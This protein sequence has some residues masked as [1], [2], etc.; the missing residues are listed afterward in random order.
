MVLIQIKRLK[1]Q[2][3]LHEHGKILPFS[4]ANCACLLIC[5]IFRTF[6]EGFL[7]KR[8]LVFTDHQSSFYCAN[9]AWIE[10]LPAS[11]P[12]PRKS[13]GAPINL[14]TTLN[15][16]KDGDYY[17]RLV[18]LY[19][20]RNLTKEADALNAFLGVMHH[21]RQSR[22]AIRTLYC[23]PF[24]GLDDGIAWSPLDGHEDETNVISDSASWTLLDWDGSLQSIDNLSLVPL[25]D[26]NTK[27]PIFFDN[28]LA[29]ALSWYR[30]DE[31]EQASHK[32]RPMFPSWTWI[33]WQGP[34]KFMHFSGYVTERWS[35]VRNVQLEDLS[36]KFLDLPVILESSDQDSIQHAL[37]T[38]E[39]VSFEALVILA[40]YITQYEATNNVDPAS[41]ST[42]D[43]GS[44]KVADQYV[45]CWID[46][47]PG[48]F[49]QLAK[50]VQTG[51]WTCLLIS[52]V[53]LRV[54]EHEKFV[55]VVKWEEDQ[56]TA[57]RV[58]AFGLR[59]L[60]PD[61]A[62]CGPLEETMEWRCV[63]LV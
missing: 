37:S 28:L 44:I 23:L 6:Q 38:V 54:Y 39:I 8:L 36:G 17:T 27:S 57:E 43:S 50:N 26:R 22:P 51:A 52:A 40:H 18:Q 61:Q 31:G 19:G 48:F 21:V 34:V 41:S 46:P 30:S 9:G 10:T 63:R 33:G 5:Q 11:G 24:F 4:P 53:T 25:E 12:D 49:S 13:T 45:S 20:E 7:S 42:A 55:L 47:S 60:E 14:F 29:A 1:D 35:C 58:G 16:R 56:I 3:G 62:T 15:D 59:A 32:R 2:R